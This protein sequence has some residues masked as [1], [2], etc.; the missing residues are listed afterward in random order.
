VIDLKS[1]RAEAPDEGDVP[2]VPVRLVDHRIFLWAS[3]LEAADTTVR[4]TP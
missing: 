3:A 1:G 2:T 4:R